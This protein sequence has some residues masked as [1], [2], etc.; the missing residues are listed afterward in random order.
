MYQ[1]NCHVGDIGDIGDIGDVG[2]IGDIGDIGDNGDNI[3][4]GRLVTKSCDF[5][6]YI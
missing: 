1:R 4:I 2:D 5:E 3:A 6:K